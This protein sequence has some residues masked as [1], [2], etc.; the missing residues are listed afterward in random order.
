MAAAV[1]AARQMAGRHERGSTPAR[2]RSPL[3]IAGL[4]LLLATLL[5]GIGTSA[6]GSSRRRSGRQG[7]LVAAPEQQRQEQYPLTPLGQSIKRVVLAGMLPGV[8]KSHDW[9]GEV[10]C[11]GL[12]LEKKILGGKPVLV[13]I[14]IS[15]HA[16][17][18]VE[19]K[20]GGGCT[21][22]SFPGVSSYAEQSAPPCLRPNPQVPK[23][24]A[25]FLKASSLHMPP[26]S[27]VMTVWTVPPVACSPG[28]QG[29][30]WQER[31]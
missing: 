14:Q 31:L 25:R 26:L 29:R 16:V 27:F 21:C 19:A 24:F 9:R 12:N 17:T 11:L 6:A 18:S 3:A 13:D 22:L 30:C 28:Q 7:E 5:A 1:K 4:A 2:G 20:G 10:R 23:Y 15:I 8:C